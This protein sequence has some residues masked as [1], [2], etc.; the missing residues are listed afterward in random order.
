[1]EVSFGFLELG[2]LPGIIPSAARGE[3]GS[4]NI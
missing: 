4:I 2:D 1:L 3:I